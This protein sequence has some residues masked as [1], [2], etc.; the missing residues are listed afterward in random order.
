MEG[1]QNFGE[2]FNIMMSEPMN[3]LCIDC[4]KPYPLFAS[5]NNA[6]FLCE[7]CSNEHQQLG[8]QISFIRGLKDEWDEY[9]LLYMA[10]GGNSR[11]LNALS[12][13]EIDDEDSKSK[14]KTEGIQNYR[15]RVYYNVN[16]SSYDLKY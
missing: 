15:L 16:Y 6:V 14:Y 8:I 5:I 4:K 12:S 9:L 1:N 10:R 3:K 13:Y 7:A 2:I 11:F